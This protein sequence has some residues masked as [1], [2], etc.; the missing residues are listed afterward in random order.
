MYKLLRSIF[1]TLNYTHTRD[2]APEISYAL[3]D[4]V[5]FEKHPWRS[6][7]LLKLQASSRKRQGSNEQFS[8]MGVFM[9]LE[10]IL[11]SL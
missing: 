7:P 8:N 6:V 11:T 2:R 4:L 1:L 9:K 3:R 5:Q 10:E